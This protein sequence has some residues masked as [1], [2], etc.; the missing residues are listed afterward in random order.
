[1]KKILIIILVLFSGIKSFGQANSDKV[2]KSNIDAL[3]ESYSY[4]NRFVGSVLISKDGKVFYQKS[5]GSANIEE[6][7]KNTKKT[8]FGIASH[9][10]SMTAVA[11]LKLVEDG[12]LE[13]ETPISFFFPGFITDDSKDITIQHLLNNSSG[14]EANIGRKDD[15]GN[16]LMPEETAI[17]FD[18]VLEKFNNSKLKFEPGTGYDYNNFGYFLLAKIIEKVSGQAYAD[19]ME[20]AIFKPAGLKNTTIAFFKSINQKAQPYL[21]LGMNSFEEFNAPFHPSWLMGAA[22]IN[23]TAIDL[24][25]FMEAID[26]GILL[27][28]ASV[29]KIYTCTQAIGVNEMASGLGWV[30]D[31]KGDERWIYNNGLLPGYASMMGSLIKQNI[32]IIILSN[33]TSVNPVIDDF[34]G[35]VT[36]IPEIT[37]KIISLF[38]GKAV[39][40]LSVPSNIV[41]SSIVDGTKTYQL[42]NGHSLLLKKEGNTYSL[43]TAGKEPWSVFTYTFSRNADEND[44]ASA[45]AL[46][47]ANAM[48]SQN[49][50][51]LINYANDEMKVFLGSE[52]G[53]G[54]LKGMWANFLQHAG[55]FLSYN[56]YK[57][58]GDESKNVHIRFHF[59]TIDIGIA[60][61]INSEYKIQGMFM[62]DDVKTS[63]INTVELILISE[64]EF[65]INGF[66]N[67]GMQDLKI[68]I[69]DRGLI[70]T[71][72]S[73]NF[74]ATIL[75]P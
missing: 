56:I 26:N 45:T 50:E 41:S 1:M 42:D 44:A 39:E 17:T 66:Q 53:L 14:M 28:P 65:F 10:K 74:D 48:S 23:S 47:F 27:K 55:K 37:D 70:L 7:K 52:E 22:D 20:Q 6:R 11:I 30:I 72:G 29:H 49:F 67:G 34:Q 35:E 51:G 12:K 68:T 24:L 2:L 25:K 69:S 73:L 63:H 8:V 71:D 9:T 4:Y 32:K 16:G 62:D 3:L 19:F 75:T 21:G 57:I 61:N 58:E 54:Q 15:N 5:V 31:H 13:L 38:Q 36:F 64:D 18:E 60:L 40:N 46:F 33:A 59:E 43:E